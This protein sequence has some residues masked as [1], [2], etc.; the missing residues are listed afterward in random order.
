MEVFDV[1][2]ICFVID[3]GE[4]LFIMEMLGYLCG[5]FDYFEIYFCGFVL[6]IVIFLFWVVI[7]VVSKR[8]VVVFLVLFLVFVK[9]MI[10]MIV[11]LN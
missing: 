9:E 7:F 4:I 8:V 3:V 6:K 5:S 11:F 2:V 1:N 10:G